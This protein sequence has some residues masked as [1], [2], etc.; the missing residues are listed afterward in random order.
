MRKTPNDV[1]T[2]EKGK[3]GGTKGGESLLDVKDPTD[4]QNLHTYCLQSFHPKVCLKWRLAG[5]NCSL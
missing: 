2:K 1:N 3:E 4:E 5:S